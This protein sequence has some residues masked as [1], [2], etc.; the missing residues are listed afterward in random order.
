MLGKTLLSVGLGISVASQRSRD[1]D[2]WIPV[3]AL[4]QA[5]PRARRDYR[6]APAESAFSMV[7]FSVCRGADRAGGA[8]DRGRRNKRCANL[9]GLSADSTVKIDPLLL[10]VTFR[11]LRS[12][13]PKHP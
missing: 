10:A 7:C 6:A 11:S 13:S 12:K 2:S 5:F 8:C 3:R 9:V 4:T 1:I